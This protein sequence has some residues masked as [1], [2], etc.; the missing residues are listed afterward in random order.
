M[1]LSALVACWGSAF[2]LIEIGLQALPP[3]I[4]VT[5][6]LTIAALVLLGICYAR[7]NSLRLPWRQWGYFFILAAIGMCMPFSLIS[8]GQL[9][10]NSGLAG[11]LMAI[12]PLMTLL[13]AHFINKNERITI[14]KL[15][16]FLTGFAGIVLLVGPDALGELGGASFIAQLA[17][18]GGAICY[19][20][21][22]VIT[23]FNQVRNTLVTATGTML[24]AA[25]IMLLLVLLVNPFGQIRPDFEAA[26]AVLFLGLFSTAL[27]HLIFY[28][29]IASAGP[30]FYSLTGYLIPVW[31]V[32]LGMLFLQERLD[33]NAYSALALILSGIAISQFTRK[34][35]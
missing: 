4:I 1:M 34:P 16:G 26:A 9:R 7:G 14:W 15:L 19:A 20:V 17:V 35:H 12:T 29:L 32:I 10:I 2:A 22:G 27:P 23:P 13:L 18:I 28:R 11:I 24:A 5:G 30:A 3:L 31:A 21:N 8:W 6:R 33:W 25:L